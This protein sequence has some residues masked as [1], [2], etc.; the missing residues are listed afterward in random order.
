VG[1]VPSFSSQ[2]IFLSY[3]REDAIAYARLLKVQLEQRF[4]DAHVFMDLDS[5]K[6]GVDFAE[7]IRKA[8]DSCA[9]L[10]A[11][12]GPKWATLTDEKERRRLDKRRDWVRF[13]VQTALERGVP[14]I[15]VLVDGAKPLKRRQLPSELQKLARLNAF[16]W[17]SY[18]RYQDDANRLLDFMQQEAELYALK[19]ADR[20]A[21]H[22]AR[23]AA[24][25]KAREAAE[26]KAREA[27]TARVMSR[28]K[29][30]ASGAGV[31]AGNDL[32]QEMLSALAR[33]L[34]AD[35]VSWDFPS[36]FSKF[37]AEDEVLLNLSQADQL[38]VPPHLLLKADTSPPGLSGLLVVTDRRLMFAVS[39]PSWGDLGR[40]SPVWRFRRFRGP[41]PGPIRLERVSTFAIP[42]GKI[43]KA[44]LDDRPP[45]TTL[46][47]DLTT[48]YLD[49]EGEGGTLAVHGEGK[50]SV[51]FSGT[52]A[53]Q[54][55][56]EIFADIR[57]RIVSAD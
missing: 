50:I 42:Y 17:S 26:R 16:E 18:S 40:A 10:V 55:A 46:Y 8:V 56:F 37:V 22:E 28:L 53:S 44:T 5:I 41:P 32:Y 57:A 33:K 49:L 6:P 51:S 23:E 4:G 43:S 19:A 12:I 21:Q 24:E 36:K 34:A 52:K 9:V 7:E 29:E 45:A 27:A 15:P 3:R 39:D 14:V 1:N 48:L 20:K 54:R 13:E 47:L 30:L 31:A 2:G 35:E 11:L 38:R 25:R